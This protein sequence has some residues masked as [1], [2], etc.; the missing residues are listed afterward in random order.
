MVRISE[1]QSKVILL[2]QIEGVKHL[3]V[4]ITAQCFFLECRRWKQIQLKG[5][6]YVECIRRNKNKVLTESSIDR[7]V[8]S[9]NMTRQSI[10]FLLTGILSD[11][12]W[13]LL[14]FTEPETPPAPPTPSF[15]F[16]FF[17]LLRNLNIF[18]L[19]DL[20]KLICWNFFSLKIRRDHFTLSIYIE[21]GYFFL[22]WTHFNHENHC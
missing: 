2:R 22:F 9:S 16:L 14:A 19:Y 4:E 20:W 13:L 21:F 17:R 3:F 8:L 10:L 18:F 15:V 11:L 6:F 7:S 12:I 1:L 5:H